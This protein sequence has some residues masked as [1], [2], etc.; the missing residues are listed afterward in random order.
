[1]E[2]SCQ[3]H[4]ARNEEVRP[5]APPSKNGLDHCN[6]TEPSRCA[7]R[8]ARSLTKPLS[9]AT[10][11]SFWTGYTPRPAAELVGPTCRTRGAG[12]NSEGEEAMTNL[13]PRENLF[14]NLF[15]FRR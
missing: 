14:Q 12:N 15:E 11:R 5:S 2:E 6:R 1:M 10:S 8:R 3:G 9:K 13:V 7:S 4:E